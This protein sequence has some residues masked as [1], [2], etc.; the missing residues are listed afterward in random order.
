MRDTP[1]LP[2]PYR[3]DPRCPFAPAS[4]LRALCAETPL[5]RVPLTSEKEVWLIT[6]DADARRV[7][8]D[9]RFSTMLTP[10]GTA[11]PRPEDR[12]LADELSDRQPGTFLEY[13]PPEHTRLRRL[14]ADEFSA[15]RMERLRPRVVAIATE[16]LDAMDGAGPPVD[17]VQAYAL[18]V[19][20]RV[21]CE[22]LGVPYDDDFD[23]E[24]HTA[25]MTDVMAPPETLLEARDAMRGYMRNLVRSCRERPGDDILGR[26]V[27]N[28]GDELSDE[29]IV[30]IGNLFLIAGHETTANML[31]LG[32]LALLRHPE[33]L[34]MVRDDPAVLHTAVEELVRYVTIANHG[35]VRTATEA[36][37]VDGQLI[38][39]GDH[40]V[41]S[42]PLANRDESRYE[43]PDRLDITRELRTSLGWGYGVHHC[44]GAPL[45]RME[46]YV[47]YPAL[48]R[49]FPTLRLAVPF[50]EIPFRNSN[51]TF[52]P[53]AMPVTW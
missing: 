41:V 53:R 16:C 15:E 1:G 51:V 4:E 34:A 44:V 13:D 10:P 43:D 39:A 38:R 48:L 3:R 5:A 28:H 30:G 45:A 35:A 19:P 29:E 12:T 22:M 24:G 40:V 14:V 52:G 33:Q 20:S 42:L 8:G 26:L 9:T 27:R 23:F 47:A 21:I 37:T 46:M 32:T 49:R 17:L 50:E 36:V 31:G 7:L 11:L 25:I 2:L 18:Q 6:R